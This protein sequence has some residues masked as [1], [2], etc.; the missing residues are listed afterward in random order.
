MEVLRRVQQER[1]MKSNALLTLLALS[2]DLVPGTFWPETTLFAISSSVPIVSRRLR[3]IV[4]S[5]LRVKGAAAASIRTAW[6]TI[7]VAI[8]SGL[9]VAT[10]I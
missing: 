4:G 1:G 5:R 6:C 10:E 7:P 2:R 8:G 3:S 9:R